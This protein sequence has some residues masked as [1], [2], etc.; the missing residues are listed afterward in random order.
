MADSIAVID[1]AQFRNPAIARRLSIVILSGVPSLVA[2]TVMDKIILRG[3]QRAGPGG[4]SILITFQ[5]R[6]ILPNHAQQDTI[7]GRSNLYRHDLA[8]LRGQHIKVGS[9]LGQVA[10]DFGADR[11]W[12]KSDPRGIGLG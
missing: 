7:V 11:A 2:S 4:R 8:L 5:W 1:T 10:L 3:G 12:V 9:A 6:A